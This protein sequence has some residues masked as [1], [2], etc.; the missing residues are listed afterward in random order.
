MA[1]ASLILL[2]GCTGNFEDYNTNHYQMPT[3]EPGMLLKSMI[4]S[5]INIQQNSSQMQDQMIGSLGG[6]FT[7]SNRWDGMN[8]DTFNQSDVWNAGLWNSS[9]T[10]IYSNLFDIEKNT[11]ASGHYYAM[12]KL[13]RAMSM[14]RVADCYGPLPYSKVKNGEFYVAYDSQKDVYSHIMNDCAY[15][16]STLYNYYLTT[17]GN[18]PLADNDPIYN[19]D[20]SKWAKLAN[21]IRLRT[22]VRIGSAYPEIAQ[23]N[24]QAILSDPAGLITSN[25]DNAFM[26]CGTMMNPYYIAASIWGD[27]RANASI[28]AYMSGY[29][30]PRMNSY[31]EKSTFANNTDRYLGMRSGSADFLKKDVAGYSKPKVGNYDQL[32]VF[33]AAETAFLQAEAKLKWSLGDKTAQAHYENGIKLSMEQHGAQEGNYLKD[34][35]STPGAHTGDPRGSKFNYQPQTKITIAWNESVGNELKLERIITQKWIACYP[36]GIEAWAEFRRTG[37][38][39]LFPCIDNLS[40]GLINSVRGMRRLRFPYTE[41]QNNAAN[42]NEGVT[43]LSGPD[44]GTTDLVWGKKN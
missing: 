5:L 7:M 2:T 42:Y 29:N 35:T 19:G 39:E 25:E 41:A 12:A 6:Y 9:F 23:E 27:L 32:M 30:D 34:N 3:M 13:V 21:S 22:A 4:E 28:V 18:K 20:Y 36:L 8:Y 37:Y 24:I 40:N 1:I 15:A 31:F 14:L 17:S 43:M 38:P 10:R 26:E 33:C 44:N 16:S 11:Q